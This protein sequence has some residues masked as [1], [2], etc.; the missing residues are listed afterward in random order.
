MSPRPS[1][2]V[3]PEAA[4]L[5]KRYQRLCQYVGLSEDDLKLATMVLPVVRKIMPTMV[6]DFYDQITRHSDTRR[7]LSDQDQV[8]RLKVSLGHWVVDLFAG[9]YDEDFVQR[10]WRVGLRHVEVG[11]QPVWVSAAMS[12]L[13]GH[14]LAA[15]AQESS[16]SDQQRQ[17]LIGIATR[18]VDL[19]L[20]LIQDAYHAES[21]AWQ[22]SNERNFAE[23]VIETAQ[24]VVM[25]LDHSGKLLRGNAF[26]MQL[27]GQDERNSSNSTDLTDN[28][29]PRPLDVR[30]DELVPPGEK[31]AVEAFLGEASTGNPMP[32]ETS[33]QVDGQGPR[34]IRWHARAVEL[35]PDLTSDSVNELA[36]STELK[37]GVLC[38]G[39]DITDL[40]EA[41]RLLVRHERLAAIGQTMA[42]LAHESRN[43]F[44]RSQAALETLALELD[45]R[46]DSVQLIERIQR[47][48]D[49][50][51]H[52]Y[53]EVL[54]FARP[55]RLEVQSVSL[56]KLVRQTWQHIC[57]GGVCR[58]DQIEI[59][60]S[61]LD[62]HVNADPFALEQVLR[63]V[64]ENALQASGENGK[65]EVRLSSTWIGHQEA[66]EVTV[67][68]FGCGLPP[69]YES[70]LFEPFFTT[71]IRGTGL[72][73][74]I[75]R[76][77]AEAH[78][79]G[80]MLTSTDGG[81]VAT[82]RLPRQA[83]PDPQI[84]VSVEDTRRS[85]S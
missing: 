32:I 66:V 21:V 54:Q 3:M 68:D 12:R 15:I 1:P 73:L 40:T 70:R 17:R 41:Q 22:V 2:P 84:D 64:L 63:N 79:G 74:P 82:L 83:V 69:E 58:L 57:Q 61:R 77:L 60:P 31:L 37:Q 30:F 28:H 16:F 47:A 72:G 23:G 35:P 34:R 33:F 62:D 19:D 76:R 65:V 5:L 44:Q 56:T 80:L 25:M 71:R 11:L 75:A 24:A 18:L 38:V 46:P 8:K 27:L 59:V 4:Q 51:L 14:I 50:L 7:V 81:A 48:H 85:G 45:D 43:A 10:R 78:G 67:R 13:R 42:G 52:L 9:Q 20:T 39:Q 53:E 49:H 36:Q 29:S 55:V 26:L 6:D